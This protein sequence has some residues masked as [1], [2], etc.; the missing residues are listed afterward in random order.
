MKLAFIVQRY[1][2]D[3]CGGAELHCRVLAEHLA[4]YFEVEVLTTCAKDHATWKNEYKEGTEK[5]NGIAVHR[6]KSDKERDMNEFGELSGKIFNKSHGLS[7]E[8]D[9][10][11]LQG[12]YCPG[13]IQYINN[14]KDSYDYFIFFTYLYFLT[15]FGIRIAPEKSL[16]IPIAASD[17]LPIRLELFN[18]V[19]NLPKAIIY[20]TVEE[21]ESINKRF[22][23]SSIPSITI[24][25]GVDIPKDIKSNRFR[26]RFGIDKEFILYIGRIEEGKG[27]QELF[28]H[29]IRYNNET[30]SNLK[31]VLM[32]KS[33]MKIPEHKDIIPLGFI[34]ENEG[35]FDVIDA[36]ALLI[37]PSPYE[38]LSLV[39]LEAFSMKKPVLVNGKCKALK[40]HCLNSNAGLYYENYDEFKEALDLLLSDKNLRRKMGLNGKKYFNANYTWD[41]VEKA[42]LNFFKRLNNERSEA[43]I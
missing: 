41:A 5:I 15:Y 32:G 11:K 24:G 22:N 42:Y 35:K 31:L 25:V 3:V 36:C 6:F 40:F 8:L 16:F 18:D 13:L 2:L 17:D 20:S 21:K 1:G 10:M 34:S 7:E 37:Q 12:P 9:W 26:K 23:N 30:K 14:N 28:D 4:K 29:F 27:C 19:F 38:C 33:T 43:S 39:L